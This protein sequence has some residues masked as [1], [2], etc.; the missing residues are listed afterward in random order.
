MDSKLQLNYE[1]NFQSM[2]KTFKTIIDGAAVVARIQVVQSVQEQ[3]ENATAD[4]LLCPLKI[5]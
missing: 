2:P 4:E 3:Y 5:V 1:F